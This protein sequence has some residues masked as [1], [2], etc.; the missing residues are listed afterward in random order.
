MNQYPIYFKSSAVISITLFFVLLLKFDLSSAQS[1]LLKNIEYISA[2]ADTINPGD[3]AATQ[4][5]FKELEEIIKTSPDSEL[6]SD[7]MRVCG[8]I[9]AKTGD[10][11]RA[12][13]MFEKAVEQAT[14]LSAEKGNTLKAKAL[15][16]FA[17]VCQQ[18]GDFGMALSKYLEAE[19]LYF[20]DNNIPALIGIYSSLGDLYDKILQPEK[21][22]EMNEKA[23]ELSQQTNDTV[24]IVKAITGLATN[25]CNNDN[26]TEAIKLYNQ[27]VEL[28]QKIGNKQLEHVSLYD[29]GFA[30]SRMEDYTKAEEMYAKSYEVAL[31]TGNR[32]DIGDALYKMGLMNL[33]SGNL[34]KSEV[35]LFK[36]LEIARDIQS[37]ILERNIFDVLY[38]LEET[39]GNYKKAYEYLNNYIDIV[40]VIFSE[41]DQQQSNFLK[42]RFDAE[43]REFMISKLESEKEIQQLKLNQQR[44]LIFGLFLIL[45]FA[46]MVVLFIVK[47]YRYRQNLAEKHKQLQEQKIIQLEKEKQ[48]VATQSLLAGEEIE[49]TRLAGDLHDGLGGML[50][51]VKLK[52]SSMKENSIITSENLAHFNHALD[53]LDT[54]IAEM[55]RVAHNLMPETLM[56]YGLQTAVNDFIKQ[57][58]PDGFPVIRFSLFGDDLRYEKELEISV[59]RIT[60]EL[61]NNALKHAAARQIDVQLFTEKNRISVQVIDDGKGFNP[62]IAKNGKTSKGLKNI[63]D[64]ITAF[65][66]HLEILS[67]QGKGTEC[68]LEFLIS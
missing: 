46:G 58:E 9:Y 53:L 29:L 12:F 48:L 65:N 2:V 64:R 15:V 31:Q 7:A 36:A 68:T 51:G 18:N 4:Q 16:S 59:Y 17:I 1:V 66:G 10:F 34:E 45:L 50:T 20:I 8:T 38:S 13:G 37:K 35:Q 26:Y 56:H 21:R 6:V 54:S 33:Y 11:G 40:Y 19:K 41:D 25:L 43:K 39:R 30:Y 52:L 60:Q 67:E 63:N 5:V 3:T 23:F 28:S 22:K 32:M 57:V 27:T 47:R 55:R 14:K 44:W 42:A 61:V 24:A 49:R 62:E